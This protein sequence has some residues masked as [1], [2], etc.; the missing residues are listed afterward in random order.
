MTSTFS[1]TTNPQQ[2]LPS[3]SLGFCPLKLSMREFGVC[4]R[5]NNVI[6]FHTELNAK[7]MD[8]DISS[9]SDEF[10]HFCA[11]IESK[12]ILFM[13]SQFQV[14]RQMNFDVFGEHC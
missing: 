8:K 4:C 12:Y 6:T 11:A 10:L 9:V 7:A 3:V 14:N 1:A 2:R 5:H 13:C